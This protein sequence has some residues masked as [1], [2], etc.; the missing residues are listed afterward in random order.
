MN[1]PPEEEVFGAEQFETAA[2]REAGELG[3]ELMAQV[4]PNGR[5]LDHFRVTLGGSKII[6]VSAVWHAH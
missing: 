5:I 1:F 4:R 2:P 3:L 6:D